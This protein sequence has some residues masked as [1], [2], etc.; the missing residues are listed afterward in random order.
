MLNTFLE[1]TPSNRLPHDPASAVPVFTSVIQ[2]KHTIHSV[3]GSSPSIVG[4]RPKYE[5]NQIC[6]DLH[7]PTQSEALSNPDPICCLAERHLH[8]SPYA[9]KR[10]QINRK[11]CLNTLYPLSFPTPL[12]SMGSI[13]TSQDSRNVL[14]NHNS[15]VANFNC[16]DPS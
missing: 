16:H 11:S 14:N 6:I 15:N 8:I 9:R 1:T 4:R 3:V 5:M 12:Q 10:I 7:L 2:W 13:L